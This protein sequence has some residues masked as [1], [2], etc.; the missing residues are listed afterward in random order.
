MMKKLLLPFLF[1]LALPVSADTVIS[2]TISSDTTWSPTNGVYIIDSN[3][4]VA[5]DATLTIEPGT[6]VKVRVTS[7]GG[8]SIF[9]NLIAR[10]TADLPIYFTSYRDDSVGGDSDGDGPSVG[11]AGQWQG[12]YFKPGSVGEF[13][14]TIIRYSGEGGFG[15]GNFIGIENDGGTLNIKNSHIHDNY[16]F[17]SGLKVGHGIWQKGGTLTIEDSVLSNQVFGLTMWGGVASVSSSEFVANTNYGLH[18][19]T[20]DSLE[21]TDNKFINNGKTAYITT[22]VNF[23]HDDNTS[24]DKTNRGFETSGNINSNTTWHTDDLPFILYGVTVD[25]GVTLALSPGTVLKME[26]GASMDV[27]GSLLAQGTASRPVYFT[28]LKDDLV[29]GD[30]NGDGATSLPNMTNWGG[31]VFRVGSIGDFSNS[32]IRYSGEFSGLGDDSG[33]SGIFNL[34]GELSLDKVFF[35]DNFTSDI[36]QNAGSLMATSTDFSDRNYGLIFDGGEAIISQSKFAT[37]SVAIED[38][39]V[40]MTIDAR[41]NWWGSDTGP[42]VAS[43][44]AGAGAVIFGNVLYEP[45]LTSDPSLVEQNPDPVIIVPGIMGSAY[46]NGELVI[47]PILHTYDDLIATLIANGYAEGEDLFTF[48]YEWR[49]SNVITAKLLRDKI[50]EIQDICGCQKVD[51]VAHSMGGLIAR[52]YIQS[53][54]YGDNVDQLIFLGTP[55]KGSAK[56]YLTWEAGEMDISTSDQLARRFFSW[57]AKRRGFDSLFEYIQSRPILSVQELLPTFSYLKDKNTGIVRTYPNNYPTNDFLGNLNSSISNLLDSGVDITNIIGNS[58]NKTIEKI[59][60]VPSTKPG[61]WENGEPDGFY[62]DEDDSGL[63]RGLGDGTVLPIS[64]GLLNIDIILDS[65]HDMLPTKS[66]SDVFEILTGNEPLTIIDQIRP[67]DIKVLMFQLLSPIDVVITDPDGKKIGKNFLNGTEYDEIPFAFYSGYQT[68]NEYITIINPLDGAYKVEVQG[69]ST[70]GEYRVLTSY[71]SDEFAITT[72]VTGVTTPSQVTSVS[73]NVDNNNPE[74]LKTKRAVTLDI[75]ITDINGAYDLGWITDKKVRDSLIKQVKLIIKFEK[76]RNGKYEKKV[77]K[78]L[79][80]LLEKELDL[81][82]KKG[83]INEEVYNLLKTD[84]E[85]LIN[86]N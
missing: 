70:G 5:S 64:S 67:V 43:N 84:L 38:K 12:L 9:G 14:Y 75:L 50:N 27:R 28:S 65:D 39:S 85:Y 6:I 57:E 81:L 8:P 76:K 19:P 1:L 68:D 25:P 17:L 72:E 31:I 62:E 16:R 55:H 47:D 13:N 24:A 26:S 2:G 20:G 23:S 69:T 3:F 21:L 73:V 41:H 63:E 82:L 36:Y 45:W 35:S 34:G 74:N 46:K 40:D 42:T 56:S 83:K 80:K 60:I 61:L 44:P 78:I 71:I 32:I 29:A 15:W 22:R 4:S 30:T 54:D 51:L 18:V 79:I 59:R 37:T 77:D 58:G 49:N 33:R 52:Q 10:G 7:Q 53:D 86:N 11:E 48:P 66:S